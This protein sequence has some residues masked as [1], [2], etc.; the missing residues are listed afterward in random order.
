M[1]VNVN[2]TDFEHTCNDSESCSENSTVFAVRDQE[3][4]EENVCYSHKKVSILAMLVVFYCH[5][6][7]FFLTFFFSG[8]FS[9]FQSSISVTLDFY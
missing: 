7:Y 9:D 8:I 6:K 3:D 2:T 1:L 5:E 4:V